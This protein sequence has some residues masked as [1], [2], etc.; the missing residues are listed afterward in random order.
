M[1]RG[2]IG[3]NAD[4]TALELFA[5]FGYLVVVGTLYFRPQPVL[6]AGPVAAERA[7]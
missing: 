7:E 1:L 3:Y 5:W 6:A 2:L 4:P